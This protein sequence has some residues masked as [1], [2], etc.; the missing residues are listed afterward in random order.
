[1]F[2]LPF[3][4]PLSY[5]GVFLLLLG[6]LLVLSGLGILRIEKI[7]IQPGSRT[8]VV[9]VVIIFLGG[10]ALFIE[11]SKPFS[12][13]VPPAREKEVTTLEA[14][15]ATVAP[16]FEAAKL[17]APKPIYPPLN[18]LGSIEHPGSDRQVFLWEGLDK[19]ASYY[20]LEIDCWSCNGIEKQWYSDAVGMPWKIESNLFVKY[21]TSYKSN[22]LQHV[23]ESMKV[24][25]WRIWATDLDDREGE[26]S[27]W[28]Q[29]TLQPLP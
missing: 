3:T 14:A 8:L 4:S 16:V 25:R 10:G 7:T 24:F 18:C 17:P 9:G 19:D 5:I 15:S 26:K 21:T 23:E 12:K 22:F 20:T 11:I 27:E 6:V 29:F 13:I 2:D 1:V 28:C